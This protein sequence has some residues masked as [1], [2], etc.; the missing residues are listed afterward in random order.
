[1]KKIILS[2]VTGSLFMI[3]MS[4]CA[5]EPKLCENEI[6]QKNRVLIPSVDINA[7]INE[8]I[9]K[10]KD[11]NVSVDKKQPASTYTTKILD[12]DNLKQAISILI[13]KVGKLEKLSN[14]IDYDKNTSKSISNND[15]LKLNNMKTSLSTFEDKLNDFEERIK[16]CCTKNEDSEKV[17]SDGNYKSSEEEE[18]DIL[19]KEFVEEGTLK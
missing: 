12:L 11:T 10:N 13:V 6:P 3:S 18:Y 4:G 5:K 9:I 15:Y 17:C 16:K 2:C 8:S 1:M 7:S 19:I 14:D